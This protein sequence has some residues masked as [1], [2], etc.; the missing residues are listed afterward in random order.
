MANYWAIA[1]GIN[2]YRCF[3]PLLYAQRDAQALWHYW[4]TDGGFTHDHC[5][6]LTDASAAADQT[7]T[8]PTRDNIENAIAQ[9]CQQLKPDDFLWCFFSGYGM[10]FQGQDYLMPV[11]AD[12]TQ[13]AAMG[14]PVESIFAHFQAAATNNILLLLDIN[15]SQGMLDG[16][17]VGKEVVTLA[18]QYS[19]STLLSCGPDQFSH[20]TLALRQGLFTAALLEGLRFYGC[21]TLAQLSQYISKRLPE[22]SDHHWRPRQDPIVAIP[23]EQQYQFIVPITSIAAVGA[24]PSQRLASSSE[25]ALIRDDSLVGDQKPLM[26]TGQPELAGGNGH[27]LVGGAVTATAVPPL[28]NGHSINGKVIAK[29][30][31][32]S[33]SRVAIGS[34]PTSS[35][36]DAKDDESSD[37]FWRRTVPWIA[38]VLSLLVLAVLI[39]NRGAFDPVPKDSV[40]PP[41]PDAGNASSAG[42]SVLPSSIT[43]P[44]NSTAQLFGSA[45]PA[46]SSSVSPSSPAVTETGGGAIAPPSPSPTL[47]P[48]LTSTAQSFPQIRAALQTQNY[49]AAA[50]LLDQ[51]PA[52]QRTNDYAALLRQANQGILAQAQISLSRPRALT[53]TNQASDLSTAIQLA[54]QIKQG[55]PLYQEAQQSIDR[56]SQMVLDLARSRASQPNRGSSLIAAQNYRA[57]IEAAGL[58][59]VNRSSSTTAQQFVSQWSQTIWQ[60][61]NQRA[62]EGRLDVAIKTAEQIPSRTP[63]Y[64]AA[65]QA[66]AQWKTRLG[67]SY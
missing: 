63:T 38:G 36:A 17:G 53:A 23:P 45:S 9:V 66:I 41:S 60:M 24:F 12:P 55:H 8:E 54:S 64:S 26:L 51:V 20:E 59:P 14:I 19:I 7:F 2:Q 27:S 30:A 1:I 48:V 49:R 4:V 35:E 39:Q 62:N 31:L 33:S 22:L 40:S 58:V 5:V 65:Q 10:Q 47:S 46:P 34:L 57:A 50:Q 6:L 18:Y 15:H 21:T 13:V 52:E 61:A 42:T 3:Q 16:E 56:W 37:L 43:A 11:E 25:G 32:E 28:L 29:P 67:Y 44:T